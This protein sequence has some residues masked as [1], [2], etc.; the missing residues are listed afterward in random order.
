MDERYHCWIP[1]WENDE[2]GESVTACWAE[3]AASDYCDRRFA[4]SGG[5][6]PGEVVVTVRDPHG[7]VTQFQ[8]R[9]DWSPSFYAT[10]LRHGPRRQLRED[11]L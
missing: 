8:V 6:W 4:D 10:A 5:S 2:D 9:I 1:D 11:E 7:A 3:E